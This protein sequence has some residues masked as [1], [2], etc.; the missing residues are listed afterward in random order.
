MIVFSLS[1]F[2]ENLISAGK[3]SVPGTQFGAALL[4]SLNC[5]VA[6]KEG[7]TI[8]SH[9]SSPVFLQ[10]QQIVEF[11]FLYTEESASDIQER[12]LF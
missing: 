8:V 6:S 4:A 7:T 11:N 10:S 2:D 3:V 1:G 12:K 9:V 5:S